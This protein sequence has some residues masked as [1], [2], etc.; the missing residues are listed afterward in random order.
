MIAK[1]TIAAVVPIAVPMINLVKG[2]KKTT[3]SKNGKDRIIFTNKF[4]TVKTNRFSI[5]S[6]LRQRK[7]KVPTGRPNSIAAPID[8]PTI[9]NVSPMDNQISAS[10]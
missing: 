7:S 10:Y 1:G 9:I 3:S 6:P 2:I 8:A 4:K 5:T